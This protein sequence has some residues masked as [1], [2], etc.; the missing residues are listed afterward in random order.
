V[1]VLG[2]VAGAVVFLVLDFVDARGSDLDLPRAIVR[3]RR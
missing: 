3:R 2:S 1:A